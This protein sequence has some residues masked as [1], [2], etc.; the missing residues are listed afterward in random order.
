MTAANN[1]EPAARWE[2]TILKQMK[3]LAKRIFISLQDFTKGKQRVH[4]LVS[5]SGNYVQ[6]ELEAENLSSINSLGLRPLT[7]SEF[8]LQGGPV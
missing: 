6:N 4:L 1:S 2:Q 8:R 3:A 5:M 7:N